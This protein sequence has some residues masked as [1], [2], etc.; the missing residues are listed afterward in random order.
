MAAW[1]PTGHPDIPRKLCRFFIPSPALAPTYGHFLAFQLLR[2]SH[3]FHITGSQSLILPFHLF[4]PFLTPFHGICEFT[5][6]PAFVSYS[7][8]IYRFTPL[9]FCATPCNFYCY[10]IRYKVWHNFSHLCAH[11]RMAAWLPT[12]HP[13]IPRKLCTFLHPVAGTHPYLWPPPHYST[14]ALLLVQELYEAAQDPNISFTELLLG[15]PEQGFALD[16]DVLAANY[17]PVDHVSV[18]IGVL[19]TSAAGATAFDPLALVANY[20]Q[21]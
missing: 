19:G 4:R 21:R 3:Y 10:I 11:P 13:D 14:P 15:D 16:D 6:T 8:F 1:L 20:L 9:S 17:V 2:Y 12:G 5:V 18:P 7:P